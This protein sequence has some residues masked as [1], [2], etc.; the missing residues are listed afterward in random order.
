MEQKEGA[1]PSY[2]SFKRAAEA[3][4]PGWVE[5]KDPKSG[6]LFYVNHD[7]KITTWDR[8]GAMQEP[9][10]PPSYSEVAANQ[11]PATIAA[12]SVDLNEKQAVTSWIVIGQK[13]RIKKSYQEVSAKEMGTVTSTNANGTVEALFK[14]K[15]ILFDEGEVS[16]WLEP[17][18]GE[19]DEGASSHVIQ[20]PASIDFKEKEA[21]P[22]VLFK[23]P[24]VAGQ[25]MRIKKNYGDI[26]AYEAGIASVINPDR[27]VE[28]LFG[29]RKV[30]FDENEISEWLEPWGGQSKEFAN[31]YVA[32]PYESAS[33]REGPSAPQKRPSPYGS[34]Q[35]AYG[36][37]PPEYGEQQP[38]YAAQHPAIGAQQPSYGAKQLGAY[39][40]PP[41]YNTPSVAYP[42]PAAYH[43]S[44]ASQAPIAKPNWS[45]KKQPASK[46]SGVC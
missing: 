10:L 39:G 2:N 37:Q 19:S 24:I 13:V 46:G 25:K 31:P 1:P 30:V 38:S 41:A 5:M 4:P 22:P 29:R 21:K 42:M 27:S 20:L 44:G 43:A 8:P 7:S 12:A 36:A 11:V 32:R 45:N 18:G 17:W 28:V 40:Q 6:K 14:R 9:V 16:E 35:R 34:P 15:K 23:S 26:S 3:L 33:P